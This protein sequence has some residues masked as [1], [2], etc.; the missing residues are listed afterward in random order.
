MTFSSVMGGVSADGGAEDT[1]NS[2]GVALLLGRG[3]VADRCL[4]RSL[5]DGAALA[6]GAWAVCGCGGWGI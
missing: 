4:S 1:P 3:I 2:S 5:M 6:L